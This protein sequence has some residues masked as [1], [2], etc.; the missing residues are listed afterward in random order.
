[1]PGK[2][3]TPRLFAPLKYGT[4]PRSYH[5]TSPKVFKLLIGGGGCGPGGKGEYLIPDKIWGLN[6]KPACEIHDWMYR[7][8][9]TAA[10]KVRADE[11]FL[12]NMLRLIDSYKARCNWLQ[13]LRKRAANK[14]YWVVS[15]LGGPWY[16]N[17]KNNPEEFRVVRT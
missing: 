10:D 8:G 17:K 9:E 7:F 3:L 4:Q 6:V 1:M 2:M 16:W 11:I 15:R 13:K 12:N 14:Y 5:E